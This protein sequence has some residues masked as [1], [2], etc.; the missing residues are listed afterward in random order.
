MQSNRSATFTVL[1]ILVV[2]SHCQFPLE[3]DQNGQIQL[4]VSFGESPD[5]L[6]RVQK[7]NTI[8]SMLVTVSNTDSVIVSKNLEPFIIDEPGG[9]KTIW[10]A[11]IELDPSNNL[12]V[13]VR[14]CESPLP[15]P[16]NAPDWKGRATGV[17]VQANTKST[18]SITLEDC[19]IGGNCAF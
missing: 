12:T 8:S 5:N 9:I 17:S 10:K 6:A 3:S 15:C 11:E 13:V 4:N 19:S 16:F 7:T 1:L 18:V 2:L 14:A